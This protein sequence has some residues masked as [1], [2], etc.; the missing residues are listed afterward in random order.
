MDA[1][2][3][4]QIA[5]ATPTTSAPNESRLA[6]ARAQAEEFEASFL[7]VM[8]N[9]M[10]EGIGDDPITGGG[11]AGTTYRNMLN[12]QYAKAIAD[13]GGVGIADQIY[14]ELIKIQ[15]DSQ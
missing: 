15:E 10:M 13:A 4:A 6:R 12:E 3:I 5:A 9:T 7:T 8:M 1:A 14:R 11:E 2:F